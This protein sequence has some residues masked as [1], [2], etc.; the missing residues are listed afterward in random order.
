LYILKITHP[1]KTA[2]SL[3]NT[4]SFHIFFKAF[5]GRKC[6]VFNLIFEAMS[7][8]TG[9]IAREDVSIHTVPSIIYA[10]PKNRLAIGIELLTFAMES[11]A[12]AFIIK[13]IKTYQNYFSLQPEDQ[14]KFATNVLLEYLWDAVKICTCFENYMKAALLVNNFVIHKIEG[15]PNLKALRDE[16]KKRPITNDE[17]LA[18]DIG[19]TQEKE[20]VKWKWVIDKHTIQFTT[21]LKPAYVKVHMLPADLIKFIEQCNEIRNTL[22]LLDGH[23]FSISKKSIQQLSD[24]TD[25]VLHSGAKPAGVSSLR[26]KVIDH[27]EKHIGALPSSITKI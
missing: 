4:G 25:Y 15:N 16:Q 21:M 22:H 10:H 6:N 9:F 23:A 19:T 1:N 17:L 24:L 8:D 14:R 2:I 13:E 20:K 27:Y 12:G 7:E 5:I 26:N 3:R 11:Y 18:L